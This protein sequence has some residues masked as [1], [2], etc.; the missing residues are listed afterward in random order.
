MKPLLQ[1]IRAELAAKGILSFA[2]FMEL[3]LYCPVHGYYER[4]KDIVGRHGDFMTSVSVGTLFGEMLAFQ[5]A[6]WLEGMPATGQPLQIVEAGAHDGRLALDIMNWLELHR[7]KLLSQIQYVILEPSPIRQGWQKK[8]LGG[9]HRVRWIQ[10]FGSSPF[11]QCNGIIFSN[12]LL[13]AFPVQRFG[14][15]AGSQCWFEWGVAAD[16]DRFVWTRIAQAPPPRVTDDFPN[17]LLRALPDGYT[18]ETS[19]SAEQWWKT[20]AEFL[21]RGR[22]LAF[23]YGFTSEEKF[24]PSR[25]AGT[26]RAYRSHR[27]SDDL[28]SNAG[29]QDLTAHV[30]FTAIADAGE[31]AGLKT[32]TICTQ[33]QFFANTL[34]AG[35]NDS[36]FLDLSAKRIR[37]FQTLTHPEHLGR[38]FRVLI[39][40]R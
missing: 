31:E 9:H 7:P 38:N 5:F 40:I 34:R 18:V 17:A 14:W 10:N 20:A 19:P 26:T 13:D 25:P 36:F 15:D 1:I 30:N 4:Q 2:R 22:L 12:E 37:Q 16:G 23:D 27:L 28:L 8:S 29:E 33:Q 21:R 6:E 3:A 24:S 35:Q 11:E 39:Q 32:Q